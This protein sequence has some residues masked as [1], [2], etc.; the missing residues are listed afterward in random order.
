[1]IGGSDIRRYRKAINLSQVDF[2]E[3]LGLSQSALSQ[4]E[5][6]RTCVSDEHIALL[7]ER[8]GEAHLPQAFSD[9]LRDIERSRSQGQAAVTAPDSRWL[10]LTVWAWQEGFDL[11]QTPSP[12][13]AV[14]MVLVRPADASV[15]AF[16]IE[17]RSQYWAAG[18]I[19][20][21]EQA[22][23]QEVNDG[24][25]CLVQVQHPR[26]RGTRTL[27]AIA[28]FAHP[29][30]GRTLR[31]EPISP[32]GAALPADDGRVIAVFRAIYRGRHLR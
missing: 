14:D 5:G 9:F 29:K 4:L 30:R 17:K 24:E 16:R 32:A 19:F 20:V 22:S 1:M 18:E 11:G 13:Q 6:G 3:Q 26:A 21:F 12:D 31:F 23:P 7:R 8:F 10:A 15:I 28:H 25:L 2:A 27:I